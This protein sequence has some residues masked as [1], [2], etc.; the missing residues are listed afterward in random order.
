MHETM[1]ARRHDEQQPRSNHDAARVEHGE[2]AALEG[3]LRKVGAGAAF[4]ALL[5]LATLALV[6]RRQHHRR[7][8]ERVEPVERKRSEPPWLAI[9]GTTVDAV[10]HQ[11]QADIVDTRRKCAAEMRRHQFFLAAA[12]SPGALL[13]GFFQ[14]PRAR[15]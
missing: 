9:G 15:A 2:G 4:T 14:E 1:E 12:I 3:T 5:G 11:R 13:D 7:R 8:A 10:V 6:M